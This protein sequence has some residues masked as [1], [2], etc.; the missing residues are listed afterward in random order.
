MQPANICE[1]SSPPG[2]STAREHVL[3]VVKM[4][5]RKPTSEQDSLR[6][7]M[8]GDCLLKTLRTVGAT[9]EWRLKNMGLRTAPTRHAGPAPS[10]SSSLRVGS[11]RR[12]GSPCLPWRN[13]LLYRAGGIERHLGPKRA[14]PLRGR[15]VL[16][17]DVLPT[18]AQR[19]NLA[20]SEFE[21]YLRIRD[22]HWLEELLD[23]GLR[24]LGHLCVQYLR[25]CFHGLRSGGAADHWLPF[26]DSPPLRR[27]SRWTSER[28]L[29]KHSRRDVS[30]SSK[31]V[32]QSSCRLA[33]RFF[34]EQDYG[35]PATLQ[36]PHCDGKSRGVHS[37]LRSGVEQRSV[38]HTVSPLGA[39]LLSLSDVERK[40]RNKQTTHDTG[41]DTLGWIMSSHAYGGSRLGAAMT[42]VY[43]GTL[44]SVHS[45]MPAYPSRVFA[46]CSTPLLV[47][48]FRSLS[49]TTDFF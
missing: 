46:S 12:L 37:V 25:S 38:A 27:R 16:A 15:D 33:P 13:E 36:P 19:Y 7:Q 4:K 30:T 22:I 49:P 11:V 24:E 3:P 28:I 32:L 20:V 48:F 29:E 44:A 8:S 17:Q 18:T 1:L 40:Q 14:L 42:L 23:H 45:H 47:L 31:P 5:R 39:L 9:K 6:L 34:A 35:G 26:R 10:A 43:C 21:K 41:P 2:S